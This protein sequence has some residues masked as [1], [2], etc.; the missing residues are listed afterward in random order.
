MKQAH[1]VPLSS[2]AVA[3]FKELR[4]ISDDS[5]YTSLP[6]RSVSARLQMWREWVLSAQLCNN[7]PWTS[8]ARRGLLRNASSPSC[9]VLGTATC[10]TST[11]GKVS[12][13]RARALLLLLAIGARRRGQS[14]RFNPANKQSAK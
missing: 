11:W 5:R 9:C 1:I 7:G 6:M 4:A 2:Q 10:N 14:L 12:R 8:V 13:L 3:I